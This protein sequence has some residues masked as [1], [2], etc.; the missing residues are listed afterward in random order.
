MTLAWLRL[1]WG[2]LERGTVEPAARFRP[3]GST[4]AAVAMA[5]SGVGLF[6]LILGLWAVA[7]CRRRGRPVDDPAMTGLSRSCDW[8]WDGAARWNCAR[9]PT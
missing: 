3:W 4:L 9:C 2:R 1:A 5:G 7:L 8:P 6:N